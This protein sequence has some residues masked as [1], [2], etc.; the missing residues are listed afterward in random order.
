MQHCTSWGTEQVYFFR[1]A[2]L[3]KLIKWFKRHQNHALCLK[4]FIFVM[5]DQQREPSH[6]YLLCSTPSASSLL[7]SCLVALKPETLH[8]PFAKYFQVTCLTEHFSGYLA[9]LFCV[10]FCQFT[11]LLITWIIPSVL[12]SWLT[13]CLCLDLLPVCSPLSFGLTLCMSTDWT[14]TLVLTLCLSSCFCLLKLPWINF[15]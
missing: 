2:I 10:W 9:C 15:C 8:T 11:W 12:I 7:I 6:K 3:M 14:V 4:C 5:A 13:W 1:K